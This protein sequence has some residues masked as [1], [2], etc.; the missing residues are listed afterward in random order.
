MSEFNFLKDTFKVCSKKQVKY[1]SGIY[2]DED[3]QKDL[4]NI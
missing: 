1:I 4:N 3:V 2:N